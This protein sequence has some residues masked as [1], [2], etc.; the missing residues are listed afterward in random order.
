MFCFWSFSVIS[1]HD[2]TLNEMVSTIKYKNMSEEHKNSSM[3][4]TL[5][6]LYSF[7]DRIFSIF[8]CDFSYI[9]TDIKN[10]LIHSFCLCSNLIR[11]VE[12]QQKY[13]SESIF[14]QIAILKSDFSFLIRYILFYYFF[15]FSPFLFVHRG[16]NPL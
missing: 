2:T 3:N 12:Q 1:R 10:T 6:Y 15:L 14:F 5:F 7:S 9:I 16:T 11:F 13:V 8:F 4:P